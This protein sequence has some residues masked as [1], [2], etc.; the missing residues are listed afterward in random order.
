[1]LHAVPPYFLDDGVFH[2]SNSKSSS[3][4]QISGHR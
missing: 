1:V 2:C 4:E 3:G